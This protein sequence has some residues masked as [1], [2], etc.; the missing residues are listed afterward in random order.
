MSARVPKSVIGNLVSKVKKWNPSKSCQ[1]EPFNYIDLSSID[2]IEKQI[3]SVTRIFPNKAPS[4]AR[5]IIREGDILV[6]TVR[7]N[8]NGVA[9]VPRKYNGATASTGFCVLRP[10]KGELIWALS[11]LLGPGTKIHK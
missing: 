8:L 9:Y 6:S 3:V 1:K 5:Q 10:K 11:I 7:P 4:R 2:Q